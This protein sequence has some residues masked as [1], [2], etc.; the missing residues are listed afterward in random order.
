MIE[1][2]PE[3]LKQEDQLKRLARTKYKE[4]LRETIAEYKRKG[5][6]IRIYPSHGSDHYDKYFASPRPFNRFIYKMMFTDYIGLGYQ[7]RPK[8]EVYKEKQWENLQFGYKVN[9]PKELGLKS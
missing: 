8:E 7:T 9:Y 3:Y 2:Q 4:V 5:N 1:D 6:F